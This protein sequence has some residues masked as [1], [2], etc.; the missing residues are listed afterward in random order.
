M[1][2]GKRVFRELVGLCGGAIRMYD[3]RWCDLDINVV[4]KI[5]CLA[6]VS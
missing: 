5:N 6:V 3:G 4:F 1:E 2:G